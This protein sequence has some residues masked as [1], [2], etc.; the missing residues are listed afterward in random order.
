[1][2]QT[3]IMLGVSPASSWL[4]S[5]ATRSPCKL[6]GT[7]ACACRLILAYSQRRFLSQDACLGYATKHNELL[8]P[9]VIRRPHMGSAQ[10]R[11]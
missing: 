6:D 8:K 3:H 11:A 1:M 5:T 4:L 7:T 9:N 10:G 2:I